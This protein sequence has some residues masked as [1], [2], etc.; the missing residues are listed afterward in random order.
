MSD[1]SVAAIS[2]RNFASSARPYPLREL[3]LL[4]IEHRVGEGVGVACIIEVPVCEED[5]THVLGAE[6]R[7]G[8][9]GRRRP[10]AAHAEAVRHLAP[11]GCGVVA[12]IHHGHDA[13]APN[14]IQA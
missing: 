9:D 7:L 14:R 4:E 11:R 13:G 2:Q 10:P 12:D 3:A 1:G 8:Q 5:V 6:V